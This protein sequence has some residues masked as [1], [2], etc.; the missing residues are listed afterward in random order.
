MRT[1]TLVLLAAVAA[2]GVTASQAQVFSVNA[3]GYVNKTVPA[4]GYSMIANPLIAPTNTVEALL[5][6]QVPDNT[7][8]YLW[9]TTTKQ[10]EITTFLS[11]AD[12]WDGDAY[13]KVID[14]GAGFFVKNPGATDIKITFVG[15]VPQGARHTAL[16]AGYQIVGSQVPQAGTLDTNA[17]TGLGYT[18]ANGDVVYQWST[19]KQQY[20]ISTYLGAADGWDPTTPT[21]DVGEAFFLS[22]TTAGSWDRTFSVN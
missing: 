22:K 12:G 15:E 4:K 7:Q 20:G 16:V 1:K 5:T 10:F 14:P 9:N 2:V 18:A 8:V 13:K 17:T 21:I 3:V 6:G 19:A 11:A